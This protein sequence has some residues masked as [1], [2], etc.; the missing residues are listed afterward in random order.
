MHIL[1]FIIGEFFDDFSA[2]SADRGTYI[3][4][5]LHTSFP[6]LPT[7]LVTCREMLGLPSNAVVEVVPERYPRYEV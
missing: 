7:A 3:K 5:Q 4:E 2:S 1:I 6:I